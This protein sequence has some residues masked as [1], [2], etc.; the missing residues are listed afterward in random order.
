ME[1]LF[2][3]LYPAAFAY[4]AEQLRTVA[5]ATRVPLVRA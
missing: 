1:A 3:R 4:R 5:A 2:G